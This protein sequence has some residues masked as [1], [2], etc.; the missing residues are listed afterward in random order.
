MEEGKKRWNRSRGLSV[1]TSGIQKCD[2]EEHGNDPEHGDKPQSPQMLW[3]DLFTELRTLV[4]LSP[5]DLL[6]LQASSPSLQDKI[7]ADIAGGP[8][9]QKSKS[10]PWPI[11]LLW[12]RFGLLCGRTFSPVK[13][14]YLLHL[15]LVGQSHLFCCSFSVDFGFG[16]VWIS[17]FLAFRPQVTIAACDIMRCTCLLFLILAIYLSHGR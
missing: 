8:T 7:Q 2:H 14:M 1:S 13:R 9:L 10:L 15:H 6:P 11:S 5:R 4:A 12:F 3:H 17:V 16:T